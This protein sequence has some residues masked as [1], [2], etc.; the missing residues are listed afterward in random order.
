MTSS[1]FSQNK[2]FDI[3]RTSSSRVLKTM[4]LSRLHSIKL[5]LPIYYIKSLIKTITEIKITKYINTNHKIPLN[6]PEAIVELQI[7]KTHV[8]LKKKII[9]TNIFFLQSSHGCDE[10]IIQY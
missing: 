1:K 6:C 7:F 5:Y 8:N 9:E 4:A 10:I 3:R 2:A